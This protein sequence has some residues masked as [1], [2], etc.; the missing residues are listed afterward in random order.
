MAR[1]ESSRPSFITRREQGSA[2]R[3]VVRALLPRALGLPLTQAPERLLTAA[4]ILS[5]F[6]ASSGVRH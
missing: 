1:T 2:L 3:V 4:G 6:L 5:R